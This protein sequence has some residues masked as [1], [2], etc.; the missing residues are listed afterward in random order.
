MAKNKAAVSPETVK[1][2]EAS[3]PRTF[4][5]TDSGNAELFA[6]LYKD[7]LRYDHK[8]ERWLT[9]HENWWAEDVLETVVQLAKNAARLRL[10]SSVNIGDQD[11]RKKE[12][13]W[14]SN[15]ESRARI[16][17]VLRLAR[18]EHP[19]A[20]PG[21]HWAGSAEGLMR[22]LSI[23]TCR[24]EMRA[25]ADVKSPLLDESEIGLSKQ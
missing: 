19:L 6:H 12:A 10:Q 16:E 7:R 11:L 18:A 25:D 17:S 21:T 5:R 24:N 22:R 3:R 13:E 9:W 1:L 20:D 15:S 14:A 8:H 4:Q 2:H 23:W